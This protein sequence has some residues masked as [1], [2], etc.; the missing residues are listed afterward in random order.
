MLKVLRELGDTVE[1]NSKTYSVNYDNVLESLKLF[2]NRDEVADDEIDEI[3]KRYLIKKNV[4]FF[5]P[6][7]GI[8]K[9]QSR[10]DLV[11]IRKIL[12]R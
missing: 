6:V 10:L 4:L 9:P 5:D 3:S 11:A 2:L 12:K 7:R 8:V 1:V